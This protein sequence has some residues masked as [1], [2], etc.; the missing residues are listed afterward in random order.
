MEPTWKLY[1][2]GMNPRTQKYPLWALLGTKEFMTATRDRLPGLNMPLTDTFWLLREF[3]SLACA[4][5]GA[6]FPAARSIMRTPPA[7]L[8]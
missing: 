1:D 2:E 7:T 6:D 3:F 4:V 8:L 5:L